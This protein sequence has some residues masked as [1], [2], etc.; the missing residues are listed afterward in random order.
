M[1]DRN[2][3]F[4]TCSALEK[5]AEKSSSE[6][7]AEIPAERLSEGAERLA[8]RFADFPADRARDARSDLLGRLLLRVRSLF[9][10][11]RGLGGFFLRSL[12]RFFLRFFGRLR[13]CFRFLFGLLCRLGRRALF[14]FALR[15]FRGEPGRLFLHRHAAPLKEFIGGIRI[16]RG[17]VLAV[18]ERALYERFPGFVRDRPHIALRRKDADLSRDIG[19][20]VLSEEGNDR[21]AGAKADQRFI[22]IEFR[23]DAVALRRRFDALLFSRRIRAQRVLHFVPSC[24]RTESGMS[25]GFC[26]QK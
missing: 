13:R 21:F 24:A 12:L 16:V 2:S 11:F 25:F 7:R 22:G 26:V 8:G 14:F 19:R 4:F 18:K 1:N 3:S 5:R 9:G 10:F 20:A 6:A 15:F 17:R 23:I